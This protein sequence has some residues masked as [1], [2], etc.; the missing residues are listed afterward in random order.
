MTR[1]Q[2]IKQLNIRS[3]NQ[4]RAILSTGG[5][6]AISRLNHLRNSLG[7]WQVASLEEVIASPAFLKAT[8][9]PS[10]FP[11]KPPFREVLHP[12]KNADLGRVLRLIDSNIKNNFQRLQRQISSLQDFDLQSATSKFLAAKG[13][14]AIHIERFGWSH[15]ILRRLVLAREFLEEEDDALEGLLW[16]AG[17]H[18]NSVM[19]T[20]LIHCYAWEQNYLS[21]KRSVLN[22]TDRGPLNQYTRSMA[23]I[24]FQP[25]AT[26]TQDLAGFLGDVLKCSLLDAS[27]LAK[28]NGRLFDLNAYPWL[29]K[30]AELLGN[31]QTFTALMALYDSEDVESEY[32]FYKHSSAWLEY[33]SVQR[34]RLLVDQFY[35]AS[36]SGELPLQLANEEL[37]NWIIPPTLGGLV[38]KGPMTR[39]GNDALAVL[40]SSGPVTRSALFN[41]WLIQTEGQVGFARA[42]LLDLM[43]IT[44]DLAKTVPVEATR[45][46][47]RLSTDKVVKFVLLLLLAKRSKNERDDFQLRRLL[48]EMAVAEHQGSLI[49]LVRSFAQEYPEVAEYIYDITTEDFLAK[50]HKL[51]PHLSD[52]PE[53][54]AGLHEWRAEF[55]GNDFYTERARAV[56]I[57][58]QLNRVRNEI[59]DNRIYVDPSRFSSWIND[60]VMAELNGAL[61]TAGANK[62]V[63]TVNCDESVLGPVMQE[64]YLAFCSNGLFGI[65]SYIGRRIRHG[66]FRG[67]LYSSTINHF[68]SAEKYAPL[69]RDTSFLQRWIRWKSNYD[70]AVTFIINERLHVVSKQKPGGLLNPDFYGPQKQAILTAAVSRIATLYTETK[71]TEDLDKAITDYCWRLAEIDLQLVIASLK[72]QQKAIKQ[73]DCLD[74]LVLNATPA[75]KALANELKREIIYAIDKRMN[76]MYGWFKKPSNVSPRASLALLYNAVVAEVKDSV[77]TFNPSTESSDLD[78]IELI[79]GVYHVLYDSFYVVIANAANYGDPT[80]PVKRRFSITGDKN[81]N[82]IVVE[83]ASSI[84]P[85]DRPENVAQVINQRKAASH[86]DAN[87][88]ERRSGIPKIMQLAHTRKEFQVEFLGVIG[89]EVVVRFSH[90]LAH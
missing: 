52:I 39:Y 13:A 79:G 1:H 89:N 36:A 7:K 71:S 37:R 56:R 76:S 22:L 65:S 57:D 27:I 42:E 6:D 83:I 59:D 45:T 53:I 17:L 68:E 48:E 87:L 69:W 15:A 67:H 70:A 82:R 61:T 41:Y 29:S 64:C 23:R 26:G 43:R 20:S 9:P 5:V 30:V 35:D 58:H 19:V 40:E 16:Q 81:E 8:T 72:S 32:S 33:S 74:E 18:N 4:L 47:A 85:S 31:E 38:S 78:D 60:E 73:L 50:L 51:A 12:G 55:T 75:N 14:I 62:K 90:A 28:F 3:R 54:R 88:Y 10:L 2:E 66:T 24:A 21:A 80:K 84:R 49:Q 77:P 34:Y 46:A 25:Y 44:R 86:E 63:Q 11:K